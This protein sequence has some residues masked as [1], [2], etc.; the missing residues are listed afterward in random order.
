MII[1]VLLTLFGLV[2]TATASVFGIGLQ[3]ATLAIPVLIK[4][5]EWLVSGLW[6]LSGLIV[7]MF[8]KEPSPTVKDSLSV[9]PVMEAEP[10]TNIR[11][12][13]PRSKTKKEPKK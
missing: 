4:V 3:V 6:S 11:S 9:E 7:D 5:I 8:H 12:V 10:N 1:T 2:K 13:S